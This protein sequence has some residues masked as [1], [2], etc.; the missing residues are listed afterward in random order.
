[1]LSMNIDLQGGFKLGDSNTKALSFGLGGYGSNYFNNY[2]TF[3]GYEYFALSGNSFM[4]LTSTVDYEFSKNHHFIFSANFANIADDIF[5]NK[6]WLEL[7]TYSGYSIGYGFETRF[8]PVE[9]KYNWTGDV[10]Y[11]GFIV[12]VGY[13]F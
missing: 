11:S 8:G 3:Y 9:L 13:W 6:E 1:M 12:G 7:P 4:K 2:T 5:L 10:S